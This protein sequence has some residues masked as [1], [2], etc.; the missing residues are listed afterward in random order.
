MVKKT[1]IIFMLSIVLP[2]A[3]AYQ[4]FTD[5]IAGFSAPTAFTFEA[6]EQTKTLNISVDDDAIY[7]QG[8][9]S[10]NGED[11][12]GFTFPQTANNGWITT[13]T[14][15]KNLPIPQ[16]ASTDNYIIVYS[17]TKTGNVW[18]CHNN[19]W[20]IRQFDTSIEGPTIEG[21]II[22][23]NGDDQTG[24]GSASKPFKTLEKARDALRTTGED[25]VWLRAGTYER[26]GTFTLDSRD[27]G[28][29]WS[30]YP[31]EE[32]MIVGG[33]TIEGEAFSTYSSGILC[34]D[35]SA[36]TTN[37]GSFNLNIDQAQAS[38]LFVGDEQAT[39][40]RWP[41]SGWVHMGSANCPSTGKE[42]TECRGAYN[43][44][45]TFSEN[46]P[47]TWQRPA[48]VWL[49]VNG[50]ESWR[51]FH[52]RVSS[53][54]GQGKTMTVDWDSVPA[55]VNFMTGIK[56]GLPYYAYNIFEEL[57]SPNEWYLDRAS[58]WLYL[59]PPTSGM[60]KAIFPTI[61]TPIITLDD[62]TYVTLKDL[63]IVGSR[64]RAV[65]VEDG[66]H[67][68]IEGCKVGMSGEDAI[69]AS[70][71]EQ[72]IRDNEILWAKKGVE[73]METTTLRNLGE[74]NRATLAKRQDILI[75]NNDIHDMKET[76]ITLSRDT[77]GI[78]VSH[79]DVHEIGSH[80]IQYGGNDHVIEYNDISRVALGADDN[81]ATYNGFDYLSRGH[82]IR[83]NYI[84]DLDMDSWETGVYLDGG[85]SGQT[86]Y[87]NIIQNV[88]HCIF[89]HGGSQNTIYN[90]VLVN[91]RNGMAY[92]A[93]AS[94]V[95]RPDQW[96]HDFAMPP[97]YYINFNSE[98]WRS[99]YPEFTQTITEPSCDY[100]YPMKDQGCTPFN[101]W[102]W[103]EDHIDNAGGTVFEKNVLWMIDT[104]NKNSGW[105][106][107]Q[108]V[109]AHNYNEGYPY[110]SSEEGV[111]NYMTIRNNLEN[112]QVTIN[113]TSRTITYSDPAAL[114]AI[115]FAQIPFGQI[116]V[117][118]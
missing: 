4:G 52:L 80:G 69:F 49:E 30:A 2:L 96:W 3:T 44:W 112:V 63:S 29:T 78:T 71:Y 48:E 90:N 67:N 82:I 79:N 54:D 38:L 61:E 15:N 104:D 77:Y 72:T 97:L 103:Q 46:D 57:D 76:A 47:T 65:S 21:I 31:G 9:Y 43:S 14:A 94:G 89:S 20:Q 86:V 32:A 102:E 91:C 12:Q 55:S 56:S 37:F 39:L 58:G 60:E 81:G 51:T 17:C 68:T 114:N 8:W 45:F 34:Y 40:A 70:G 36:K 105:V 19:Q 98:P 35:L 92:P 50:F 66:S 10:L 26:S 22:S 75:D 84:H 11:W 73:A 13:G 100:A 109:Y 88:P 113:P 118:E 108:G 117:R 33:I 83:Y 23:P 25:T 24:D 64:T 111:E 101:A 87:G 5:P 62:T 85:A 74:G 116:G 6:A 110:G 41:N 27:S 95:Y 53:I 28:T 59:S 42:W 115:G 107:K 99:K 16:G 1:T 18:D 7:Y 93:S 106:H